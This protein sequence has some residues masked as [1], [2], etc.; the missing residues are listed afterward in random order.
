ATI[1]R[2]INPQAGPDKMAAFI[3]AYLP[4]AKLDEATVTKLYNNY[5]I[6]RFDLADRGYIARLHPLELWLV[7]YL[8][9]HPQATLAQVNQDS[10]AER[11]A[12]Y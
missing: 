5:A 6:Q 8:R 12:V 10:A 3:R 9:E 2:S 1:F 7:A 4:G 11:Q